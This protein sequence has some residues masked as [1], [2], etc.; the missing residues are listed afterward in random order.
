MLGGDGP[1]WIGL[2]LDPAEQHLLRVRYDAAF[3]GNGAVSGTIEG[4]AVGNVAGHLRA[5][6]AS[7]KSGCDDSVTAALFGGE[8]KA[9]LTDF[10]LAPGS[11]EQP[12]SFKAKG[13]GMLDKLG[14]ESFRVRP[15][16]LVGPPLS[17]AW[18]K[19]RRYDALLLGPRAVEQVV[20]LD[21]PL[22]YTVAMQPQM[23]VNNDYFDYAAGFDRRERVLT[24]TRRLRIK[25]RLV[26]AAE[27]PAFRNALEEIDREEEKGVRIWVPE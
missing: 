18:R 19:Q 27:W 12:T 4:E 22:G 20:S 1:E 26:P 11:P 17:G 5:L 14:Y 13:R 2:K 16:D 10:E 15:V 23:R 7:A 24:Y 8:S 9:R 25:Q 3:D 6:V 21:L